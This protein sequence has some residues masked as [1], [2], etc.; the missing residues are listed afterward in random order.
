MSKSNYY[1]A[2][3]YTG[4]GFKATACLDSKQNGKKN[5]SDFAVKFSTL[6]HL[7]TICCA[8][9][10]DVAGLMNVCDER[11]DTSIR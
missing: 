6:N 4:T 11:A 8:L 7:Y 5:G 9:L 2:P 3:E 10:A 1:F